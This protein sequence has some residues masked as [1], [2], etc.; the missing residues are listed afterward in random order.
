MTPLWYQVDAGDEDPATFFHYF[1]LA[2]ES[3]ISKPHPPLPKLIPESLPNLTRFA[4]IYFRELFGLLPKP[5]HLVFDNFQEIAQDSPVSEIIAAAL[6]EIPHEIRA[7]L[8][9]RDQPP[10]MLSRM[11]V[12]RTLAV[13]DQTVLRLTDEESFGVA[14]LLSLGEPTEASVKQMNELVEGWV[15]GLVL[16]LEHGKQENSAAQESA[17]YFFNYFASEIFDMMDAER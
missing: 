11:Q 7:I 3:L 5:L 2:A 1:A 4:R 9:S 8:I 12:N 13:L 17:G 15:A 6:N 14:R 16:L 10:A